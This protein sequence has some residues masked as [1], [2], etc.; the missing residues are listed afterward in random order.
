MGSAAMLVGE[1]G[2]DLTQ[3]SVSS[4]GSVL[5]GIPLPRPLC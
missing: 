5:L 4:S 3:F 1:A 2:A